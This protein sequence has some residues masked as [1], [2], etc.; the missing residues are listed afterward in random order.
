MSNSAH[1]AGCEG[2]PAEALSPRHLLLTTEGK[3]QHVLLLEEKPT[4]QGLVAQPT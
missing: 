3:E 4:P 1:K 2:S